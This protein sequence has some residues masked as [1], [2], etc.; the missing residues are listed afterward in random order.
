MQTQTHTHTNTKSS[1]PPSPHEEVDEDGPREEGAPP[2]GVGA[3]HQDQI[4]DG[5]QQQNPQHVHLE[6]LVEGVRARHHGDD[7]FH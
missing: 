2:A 7:V 1:T 3:E 6:E 5:A 4:A